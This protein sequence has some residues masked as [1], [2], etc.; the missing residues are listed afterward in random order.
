[1]ELAIGTMRVSPKQDLGAVLVS[2]VMSDDTVVG[3]DL[4]VG[5]GRPRRAL[6]DLVKVELAVLSR[7]GQADHPGGQVEVLVGARQVRLRCRHEAV[8]HREDL[9]VGIRAR[10]RIHLVLRRHPGRVGGHELALAVVGVLRQ[11]RLGLGAGT[12]RRRQ[13]PGV[14]GG[15]EL[16]RVGQVVAPVNGGLNREDVR[17]VAEVGPQLGRHSFSGTNMFGNAAEYACR[18]GS[19]G[20]AS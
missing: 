18:I 10:Q 6:R 9:F 20:S 16:A 19:L 2:N 17:R 13:L 3:R 12:G 14:A 5:V 7:I 1:M 15:I 8:R 4:R 11:Q